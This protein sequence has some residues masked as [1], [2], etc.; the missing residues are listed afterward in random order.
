MNVCVFCSAQ[1]IAEPYTAAAREFATL[2]GSRGHTLV[3][4]GSNMGTMK[5]IADAAQSAGGR[6]VGVSMDLL[7]ERARPNA[8]EMIVMPTLGQRKAKLLER[9]DAIVVLPGGL[10]TLDE[11]TEILEL[12]KQRLHSKPIVFL[13]TEGFYEGLK[14]QLEH[15]GREGFLPQP[16]SE[17]LA[18]ADTP[19]EAMEY[20]EAHEKN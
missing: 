10:G 15:M 9:A 17:Y 11:V 19:R 12:K 14:M 2:V 7:K 20:S 5:T 6:I 8:D 18:F 3:W 1:E 13:N 4:G 16:L